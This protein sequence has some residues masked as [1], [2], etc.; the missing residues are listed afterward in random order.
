MKHIY[1]FLLI[2]FVAILSTNAKSSD[3]R[4][5]NLL[6]KALDRSQGTV[7]AWK[8]FSEN[9]SA[10]GGTKLVW[11]GINVTR[12]RRS[13][14]LTWI[15]FDVPANESIKKI[16]ESIFQVCSIPPE[17]WEVRTPLA[18]GGETS[19]YDAYNKNCTVTYQRNRLSV[20][21]LKI[22]YN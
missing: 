16:K 15:R 9:F 10:N 5:L 13:A 22:Y 2:F 14:G 1:T 20:G 3:S 11:Y 17:K 12:V 8:E 18:F 6:E 4:N 7:D 21:D 19:F